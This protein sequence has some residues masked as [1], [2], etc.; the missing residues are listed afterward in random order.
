MGRE[1]SIDTSDTFV[2]W[3]WLNAVMTYPNGIPEKW[4]EFVNA[5][6]CQQIGD[7]D[8]GIV[9]GGGEAIKSYIFESLF[10]KT[11]GFSVAANS[12]A[13]AHF[14]AHRLAFSGPGL[15]T[16]TILCLAA[17][18]H[19]HHS[20]RLVSI[21]RAWK[22]F[23]HDNEAS[24]VK[25]PGQKSGF[26]EDVWPKWKAAAPLHAAFLVMS[27]LDREAGRL[28]H[29]AED[30]LSAE[31]LGD[32]LS[33]A[34]WFCNFATTTGSVRAKTGYTLLQ[35]ADLLRIKAG[36]IAKQPPLAPLRDKRLQA[37]QE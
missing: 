27:S 33:W 6:S 11:G 1:V 25:K 9:P 4:A 24:W 18:L 35:E 32:F 5:Y 12:N 29:P 30:I 7:V 21:R 8:Q 14:A 3:Q 2:A 23:A 22:V 17:Q 26:F 37:A 20:K 19:L 28:G 34:E 13:Q 16:G 15:T 36:A 31:R 10:M